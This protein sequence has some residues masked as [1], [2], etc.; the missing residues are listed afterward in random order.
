MS[1]WLQILETLGPMALM[2]T[3]LAPIA[4]IVIG[5]MKT[6]EALPGASGDEKK[7][8]V[9]TLVSAGAAATN[10]VAK[11]QVIDPAAAAA[12]SGSVIDA[13]IGIV[14]IAHDMHVQTTPADTP[15]GPV[16]ANI[17]PA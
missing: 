11:K 8:L 1:K 13:T 12:A 7:Q 16:S 10:A 14:N 9:Q 2:F 6:A 17:T 3:P 15:A 5:A 4:P